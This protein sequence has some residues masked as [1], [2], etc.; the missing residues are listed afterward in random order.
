[1]KNAVRRPGKRHAV[2]P[3]DG[4]SLVG[5]LLDRNPGSFFVLAKHLGLL[6]LTCPG[7]RYE[8]LI[9]LARRNGVRSAQLVRDLN[10]FLAPPPAR[11]PTVRLAAR[12]V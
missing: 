2:K 3:L 8:S 1:M 9:S 6:A 7:S 5:D 11:R 10:R 4:N 12:R